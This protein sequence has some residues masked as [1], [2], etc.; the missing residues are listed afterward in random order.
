MVNVSEELSLYDR[1]EAAM[2]A[3]YADYFSEEAATADDEVLFGDTVITTAIALLEQRIKQIDDPE[4][5]RELC[6]LVRRL[7][8]RLDYD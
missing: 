3:R 5:R 7:A 6:R 4:R 8:A 2:A 1:F